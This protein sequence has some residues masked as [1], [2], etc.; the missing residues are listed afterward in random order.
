MY[1]LKEQLTTSIKKL[2]NFKGG[3]VLN[4]NKYIVMYVVVVI[5]FICIIY[6]IYVKHINPKLKETFKPNNEHIIKSSTSGNDSNEVEL[7][8]FTA[9]W[10]PHCKAAKPEWDAVKSK[11]EKTKLNGYVILFKDIN[12]TTNTPNTDSLMDKYNVEGFPTVKMLK[13]GKIVN[14]EAKITQS[15]LTQFINTAI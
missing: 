2:T 4:N 15:N 7:F 9:D 3:A 5:I 13:D 6:Y 12:C 11:Y 1:N 10:C 14:F 8:I